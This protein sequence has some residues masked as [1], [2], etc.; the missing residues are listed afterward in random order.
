MKLIDYTG[1]RAGKATVLYRAPDLVLPSG[2]KHTAWHCCCDCGQEFDTYASKLS[3][4]KD[5]VMCQDC[6]I[7]SRVHDLTGK[8]FGDLQVIRR[9]NDQVSND[10]KRRKIMWL[11]KCSCGKEVIK[12]G[13]T[14]A[15]GHTTSCGCKKIEHV[16]K[17]GRE[18]LGNLTGQR[19]GRLLVLERAEN[20]GIAVRWKCQ[21]DCGNTAVVHRSSLINGGAK[22][23]GCLQRESAR[24]RLITEDLTGQKFGRLTV[25]HESDKRVRSARLWVC[26]CDC[27]NECEVSTTNL[28]RGRKRSCGCL[29]R[30]M[31]GEPVRAKE[32]LTGNRYGHLVVLSRNGD[33]VFPNGLHVP[34]WHCMCDCGN[35]CDTI[36]GS[37][38][39]G[40]TKSCGCARNTS[41]SHIGDESISNSTKLRMKIVDTDGFR[42]LTICFEDGSIKKTMDYAKFKSGQIAHPSF[43]KFPST[44]CNY[45]VTK[46][47]FELEDRVYF[48]CTDKDGNEDILTPQQMLKSM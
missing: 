5:L 20:K 4:K 45:T 41:K 29:V 19:F 36:G 9:M 16:S 2:Q 15:N 10:G 33:H 44:F 32:D 17:M 35:E 22:S 47:A 39:N 13:K 34:L 21:C 27:G 23:C 8:I 6:K 14:L 43:K 48:F 7:E 25:L 24:A 3:S 30:G 28:K 42:N 37:L 11:C 1:M 18:K 26:K 46:K 12:E 31:G 38:K 40:S